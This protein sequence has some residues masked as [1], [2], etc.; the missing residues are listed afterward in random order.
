[1]S[2]AVVAATAPMAAWGLGLIH[3]EA[4]YSPA[5]WR[6]TAFGANFVLSLGVSALAVPMVALIYAVTAGF[7]W[8]FVALGSLAVCVV[9]AA[10][11]LPTGRP[12]VAAA[13]PQPLHGQPD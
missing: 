1:M 13:L 11:F 8:V 2:R 10:L 3:A 6:G 9:L 5:H 12:A 4:C 7:F